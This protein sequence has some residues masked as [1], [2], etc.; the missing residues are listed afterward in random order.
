MEKFDKLAIQCQV[1]K[2]LEG[3][4]RQSINFAMKEITQLKERE[5]KNNPST[6]TNN[7]D[8]LIQNILKIDLK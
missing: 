7:I 4:D 6:Y 8:Q 5:Y 3:Y 2:L 1:L